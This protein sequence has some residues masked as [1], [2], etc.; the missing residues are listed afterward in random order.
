VI[1]RPA[2]D[3]ADV[4]PGEGRV[5]MIEGQNAGVFRDRE[6]RVHA[7]NPTCTHMGC[8]A[9]WNSAEETWDCPC[10]GSRFDADGKVIHGPAVKDLKPRGG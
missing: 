6:G 9:A 7:V 4:P 3:L 10:H 1:S 8:V 5:L 2:G